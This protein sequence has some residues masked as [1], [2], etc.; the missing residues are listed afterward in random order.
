MIV[1]PMAGLSSRF[2]QAGYDI[3]KFMLSAKERTLFAHSVMSFEKYFDSESFLFITLEEHGAKE[4]IENECSSLGLINYQIVSLKKPTAGQAETV[5]LGIKCLEVQVDEPLLIF[6][7][8]TF[9]PDFSLPDEFDLSKV[10]GYLETFVGEGA[11][12]SNVVPKDLS[13]YKVKA[14]S[15][16]QQASEFC[17]T[18]LYYWRSFKRFKDIYE[19]YSTVDSSDVQGGEYYIAPMYNDLIASG[20]DVRFSVIDRKNVIFCGTPAEYEQFLN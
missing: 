5:Y 2:S 7:I 17:C 18:G 4:F 20:G 15:E 13:G 19:K 11:N 1:I 3:P 9:R 6:N 10:D 8:D 14:T 12:W 16:K